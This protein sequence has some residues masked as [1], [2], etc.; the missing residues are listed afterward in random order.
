[1][2]VRVNQYVELALGLAATRATG[3][4]TL[5]GQC[6]VAGHHGEARVALDVTCT[7]QTSG[8]YVCTI[9]IQSA[10]LRIPSHAAE[11][12]VPFTVALPPYLAP[13]LAI[14]THRITYEVRATHKQWR[15][16]TSVSIPLHIVDAR[17]RLADQFLFF[18]KNRNVVHAK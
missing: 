7:L 8:G 2:V 5:V 10:L 17:F 6:S 1:M 4:T 18:G 14:D 9:P 15:K 13:S 11:L 16:P 3:G 12:G